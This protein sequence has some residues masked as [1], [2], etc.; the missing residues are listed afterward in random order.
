MPAEFPKSRLN[1][2]SVESRNPVK[3][4]GLCV[5]VGKTIDSDLGLMLYE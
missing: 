4:A 2:Y 3:V 5:L 1:M